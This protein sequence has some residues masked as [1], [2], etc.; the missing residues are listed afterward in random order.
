M[1]R[2]AKNGKFV[3]FLMNVNLIDRL[4]IV[5][6][7]LVMSKTAV[8]EDAL[9]E[10]LEPFCN[11]DGE[12]DAYESIYVPEKKECLVLDTFKIEGKKYCRIFYN[13]DIITVPVRDIVKK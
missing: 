12:V 8:L 5:A 10:Y 3:N 1:G 6:S 2:P 7:L 9:K 4:E 13:G 11:A